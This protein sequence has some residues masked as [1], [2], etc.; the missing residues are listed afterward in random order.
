R[1]S[2]FEI[3]AAKEAIGVFKPDNVVPAVGPIMAEGA[4]GIDPE[5]SRGPDF[6]AGAGLGED[7]VLPGFKEPGGMTPV[8]AAIVLGSFHH[9]CPWHGFNL[10]RAAAKAA[11]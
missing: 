8:E 7:Q 4:P 3:E 10:M 5:A 6:E 1:G 2:K 11:A 9:D